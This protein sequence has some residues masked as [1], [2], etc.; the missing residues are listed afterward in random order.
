MPSQMG[1]PITRMS[2]SMILRW[3][4]GQSSRARPSSV[5]SLTI[6]K[7]MSC[8]RTWSISM[9]TSWDAM[10]PAERESKRRVCDSEASGLREQFR[11]SARRSLN[12]PAISPRSSQTTTVVQTVIVTRQAR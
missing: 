6:P 8:S 9:D 4:A 5:A 7:A 12:S 3:I 2:A 1:V 10:I 11:N